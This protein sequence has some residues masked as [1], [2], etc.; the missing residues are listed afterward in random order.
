MLPVPLAEYEANSSIFAV[1]G[2]LL[3]ISNGYQAALWNNT[4]DARDNLYITICYYF[5]RDLNIKKIVYA[6]DNEVFT[7]GVRVN[8][9]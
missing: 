4:F 3:V 9:C 6:G 8:G 7:M 2:V 5:A 1:E